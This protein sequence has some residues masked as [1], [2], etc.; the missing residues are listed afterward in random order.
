[1]ESQNLNTE[2]ILREEI[3]HVPLWVKGIIAIGAILFLIQIPTF[4]SSLSD[5]VKKSLASTAYNQAQYS[6]AIEL[7]KELGQRYPTDKE[8]IKNIGFAYYRSGQYLETINTFNRLAGVKM[9]KKE[10]DEINAVISDIAR[11]TNQKTQ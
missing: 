8:I 9:S 10:V 1:M 7:Y 3:H 11:K 6:Q 2:N 4:F 5:A